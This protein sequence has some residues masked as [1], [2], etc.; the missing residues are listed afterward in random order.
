MRERRELGGG[1]DIQRILHIAI[2]ARFIVIVGM[3]T[4]AWWGGGKEEQK[5]KGWVERRIGQIVR[6]RE[7]IEEGEELDCKEI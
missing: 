2:L 7:R 6:E 3:N 4:V 5:K 1:E